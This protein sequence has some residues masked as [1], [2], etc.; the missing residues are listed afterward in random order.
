MWQQ[1]ARLQG[2]VHIHQPERDQTTGRALHRRPKWMQTQASASGQSG[3]VQLSDI[4][5]TFSVTS[6]GLFDAG[7]AHAFIN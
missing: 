3:P 4:H 1:T 6:A 5:Y 7:R 2:T